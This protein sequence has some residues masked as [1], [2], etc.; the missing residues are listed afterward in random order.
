MP[1]VVEAR[2]LESLVSSWTEQD[3]VRPAVP[4]DDAD[5]VG[6]RPP[7]QQPGHGH[8]ILGAGQGKKSKFGTTILYNLL[9][10]KSGGFSLLEF[11]LII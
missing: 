4:P 9:F 6:D 1:L 11:H 7:L 3:L 5:P 8:Q 2:G 10:N